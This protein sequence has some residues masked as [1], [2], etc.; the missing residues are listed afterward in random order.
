MLIPHS[1]LPPIVD[2]Q[3]LHAQIDAIKLGKVPWKSYTAQYQWIRPKDGPVP[4]WMATEYQIWYC[5]PRLIIHNIL[6]NPEFASDIDYAP[7]CDFQD[8]KRQYKDFMSGDWAWDQ[9]VRRC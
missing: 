8:E 9:C 2:H 1:N 6:A 5:D 4:G 7:H 3:D